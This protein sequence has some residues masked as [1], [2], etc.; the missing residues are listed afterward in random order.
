ME[1][2]LR[3]LLLARNKMITAPKATG[4]DYATSPDTYAGHGWGQ[5]DLYASAGTKVSVA[6]PG[7]IDLSQVL[8]GKPRM[9]EWVGSRV[10]SVFGR[11]PRQTE[12]DVLDKL[13]Y[14]F[15]GRDRGF[16]KK[17]EETDLATGGLPEKRTPEPNRLVAGLLFR[18]TVE[19]GELE[20]EERLIQL[21]ADLE[22]LLEGSLE[23]EG[24]R[25]DENEEILRKKFDASSGDFGT[26]N[27]LNRAAFV[28]AGARGGIPA[29]VL[30]AFNTAISRILKE[31]STFTRAVFTLMQ[32][33]V[34]HL[35]ATG[36]VEP[37]HKGVLDWAGP[38]VFVVH[39]YRLK[40]GTEQAWIRVIY[41][42]LHKVEAKVTKES[43]DPLTV[44][45][46]GSGGNAISPHVH[47][48]I[49][50]FDKEPSW[51]TPPIDYIDPTD[52]FGMVPRTPFKTAP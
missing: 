42:H 17:I 7:E 52:F 45:L 30:K 4:I 2:T 31:D 38:S 49:A 40:G 21:R 37:G 34:A 43:K 41:L 51:N 48:S 25:I 32:E 27:L 39:H 20:I 10:S 1:H 19:G 35:R 6:Q 47:M 14:G 28:A 12:K 26:P 18:S 46:V 36:G 5:Y 16:E 8:G 9:F 29:N 33:R 22:R 11:D 50:V 44:G 23:F 3:P 24:L 13:A 15:F